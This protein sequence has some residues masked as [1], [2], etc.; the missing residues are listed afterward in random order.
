MATPGGGSFAELLSAYRAAAGMTQETLAARA[1]LS[2]HA[3][4]LLERGARTS[5]RASTVALLAHGLGLGSSDREALTAAARR[6]PAAR[7]PAPAI[8]AGHLVRRTPFIGR[9]GLLVQ[10]RAMLSRPETRLLTL[11]GP[12]GV[13]KTRLAMEAAAELGGVY[14]NGVAVVRLSPIADPALVLSTVGRALGLPEAGD[15]APLDT[16][17]RHCGVLHLLLVLD[18]FEHVLSAGPDVVE[19]LARCPGL[20]VMATSRAALRLGAEHELPVTPLELPGAG[21]RRAASLDAIRDA[22][23]VQLFLD[24]ACASMPGF[25]LTTENATPVAAICRRLDGLPLALELAAPWLKLLAPHELLDRLDRRLDLLVD[26]PRDLPA[27]QRTLRAALG[28]SCAL[29]D[30]APRT[31]LRRL[32]VFAGSA[33]LEGLESVCQAAGALPGG[34]LPHLAVLLDQSLLQALPPDDAGPRVAMLE[35]VREYAGELLAAAGETERTARAHLEHYA[36]LAARARDE[37]GGAAEASWLE[38]LEREHDNVRAALARVAER[39][40]PEVGLR[41]ATVLW[42]LWGLGGHRRE[43]LQWLER[44]LAAGGPIDPVIRAEAHRAAGLLAIKVGAR[45]R[46]GRH[47]HE[48]LE[49]FR[50]LGDPRGCADVLRGLGQLSAHLDRYAD[51]VALFE[52]AVRLLERLD[53]RPLLAAALTN[54]GIA[55]GHCGDPARATAL[56]ERA[57]AIQRDLRNELGMALCLI[58]LGD[59]A[60]IAGDLGLARA[61]IEEGAAIARGVNSPY[62]VA[63]ALANLGDLD[64]AA[65]DPGAAGARYREALALCADIAEMAGVAHCLRGLAAVAWADGLAVRAACLYGAANALSP[66]SATMDRDTEA[67]HERTCSAV[68]ARLGPAE[69]AAAYDAGGRLSI[70]EVQ[71]EVIAPDRSGERVAGGR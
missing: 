60:R 31:L 69:F 26:G 20:Q 52:E 55:V 63:L 40:E 58:N 62:H 29:L 66:G 25:Q 41:L 30:E 8:P 27:R 17:C 18:N 37:K 13:G 64:R 10:V 34:V 46:S 42:P 51:A 45:E 19:L 2:V 48:A 28:W 3:V 6:R 39:G 70:E 56:H 11:T 49:A 47:L 23:S 54:L 61:R 33:P 14:R 12:P 38:R 1:G 36:H 43:G 32:S 59:R 16:V 22:A 67:A 53:D 9:E 65:G 57:L 50:H 4:S 21:G 7:T 68:R 44:L 5:P 15:D 71:A 24:R 35:S